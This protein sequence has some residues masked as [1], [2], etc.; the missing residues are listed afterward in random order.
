MKRQA[1]YGSWRSPLGAEAALAAAVGLGDVAFDG[2]TALWQESRPAEKGRLVVVRCT[3]DGR[4]EDAHPSEFNARTRVHEYGGRAHAALGGV[5]YFIH[6]ADQRLY[7]SD[8]GNAPRP[9]TPDAALRYADLCIDAPRGLLWCVREDHRVGGEPEN[10]LVA[11]RSDGSD[12]DEAGGRIVAQGHDFYAAPR[13]SPDGTQLAWLAWSHPDM[14][15]DGCEL[16]LAE[17]AAG[18]TLHGAR[19][20]AGSRSEAVQQPRW[21]P[22]GV[23]HCISDRSGWWNLYRW[24]SGTMQPL[25]PM[26]AEFG[27]PMWNFG[28]YDLCFRVRAHAGVHLP[29]RRPRPSGDAGLAQRA[30][31]QHR[32]AFLQ[33]R[34]HRCAAR[35]GA[36][37]RRIAAA[38]ECGVLA[39][40]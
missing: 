38:A 26:E 31:Q 2:E 13:L 9:I 16:W 23:L 32:H 4:I 6:L 7:R 29:A 15:W 21:S 5:L 19:R 18:G 22:D 27:Q 12:G 24:H 14:P 10:M 37:Q 30:T 34:Q 40:P 1:P 35:A 33:L 8:D 3:A 25:C 36:V 28:L 39:R 20:I 11:L 17:V